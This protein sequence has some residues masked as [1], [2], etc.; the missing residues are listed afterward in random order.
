MEL[1]LVS[2]SF[3]SH[4]P[5]EILKAMKKAGLTCIEWGSDIHAPCNDIENLKKL[6][7][8]QEEYGIGCCAYGTYF[9]LGVTPMEELPMY[10]QGAKLLGTDI[11]RLWCGDQ[12]SEDYSQ[13]EKENLFTQCR[14]AADMAASA[15]V[16]LC[17]ECHNK[18]YTNR[19]TA[20]LELMKAVDSPNFQMYW[21]PNQYRTPE[22]NLDYAKA[23]APYTK[24]LHVFNWEEKLRFPLKEAKDLWR[25]YLACFSGDHKLL[26]EFMPDNGLDSLSEEAKALQEIISCKNSFECIV[27]G[28]GAAGYNAACRLKQQGKNVAIVTEGVL[29]G[30]S[31]NTGSDKQTYY[32]LTLSGG[33]QDSVQLM[34]ENLF[35]GGCT[36]GDNA[37]CEAALSVRCFMHLCQL[38][39]PFPVNRYGEYVG[40]KTDHDPYQRATSAGPLTSK[41]MTEAL[42][43][44]AKALNIPVLDQLLAVEVLKDQDRVCG[45]LC[46]EKKTGKPVA[47][48]TGDLVLCTGGPGG[49][50][51]DSVY[52]L[53]H[54]GST[55]LALLAGAKAQNLT[56]WQFGLAS[57]EPRWNVSGS[58]M[59]V[60][61]RFVSI[62]QEGAEYEFLSDYFATPEEALS[63]VFLKGYQWPF[64]SQKALTGSSVID[65]LVYRET[66]LRG[67]KV[68]LDFTKNPFGQIPYEKLSA[69]AREY[70]EK[71]GVC[72]GTP[73][74]RLA[75]MNAP[76]IELYK[77][78]GVDI[79]KEYLQIALCAQ[80]CNGG[81]SVDSW[82]Q[83][84]L[85][86]LFVAGEAA[87]THGISRPGGSAL[88]AGQ[89][90]SLRAA[91][92]IACKGNPIPEENRFLPIAQRAL[93]WYDEESTRVLQNPDNVQS[94]LW[95]ATVRM[96][97]IAG[98]MRKAEDL[99]ALLQQTQKELKSLPDTVGVASQEKLYGYYKL[100][101]ILV[102]Q[103]AV[104]TAMLHWC[105]SV[106]ST[107]GSALY[108][109]P[110]GEKPGE[111]EECFRFALGKEGNRI[112]TVSL[113]ENGFCAQWRPVR[114]IP[115][116]DDFFENVWRSYR[117]NQNVY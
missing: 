17:M 57:T 25:Q 8:M 93:K 32:K 99:E 13:D 94:H 108:Y 90:G 43:K 87:G 98:A 11:L 105:N 69:E 5:E 76:A 50:Y 3:R 29:T 101:D 14:I 36:D 66:V 112:Q 64:D 63:M 49:I 40:Y 53:G 10:I 91:T 95:A 28:T 92:Y 2:V 86:G 33:T 60:L 68:Y 74:Q 111:L 15:G 19:K 75:K 79:T 96:S 71:A 113:T 47:F 115:Q 39:V 61:P 37:L 44:E 48:R 41:F 45:L 88:N 9:R 72:F 7:Q 78:K 80:H 116:N 107:C 102:T 24:H 110:T 12:N 109:T 22:E 81:I 46:I 31:R 20:A 97:S 83:T 18:T 77:S 85:R 38:G 30:T 56:L 6:A 89:V 35:H 55:G 70:L 52:P 54:T 42:E 106:G 51:A 58:Y 1:G 114:P 27:V 100:R 117:E 65:L 4:S 16:I 62:D 34:A 82:W 67:R 103:C 23:I 21:Q 73:V 59:Q 84:E 26:L 104:L